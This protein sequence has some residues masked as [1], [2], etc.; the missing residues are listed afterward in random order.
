[1]VPRLPIRVLILEDKSADAE[2]MLDELRQAG[3]EPEWQRVQTKA[4]Y[5]A[6]LGARFDVILADH[7]LQQLDSSTALTLLQDRGLDIPFIVV[8]DTIGKT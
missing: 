2:L 7:G 1:M 6:H 4:E 8:S 5:L 3:F